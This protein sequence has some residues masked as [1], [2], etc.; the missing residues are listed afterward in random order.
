MEV[1]SETAAIASLIEM[2]SGPLVAVQHLRDARD[3][4]VA[5][6]ELQNEIKGFRATIL[7]CNNMQAGDQAF[8]S[9]TLGKATNL[10]D[11]ILCEIEA[12]LEKYDDTRWRP[13]KSTNISKWTSKDKEKTR[14]LKQRLADYTSNLGMLVTLDLQSKIARFDSELVQDDYMNRANEKEIL[15][16]VMGETGSGKSQ[17]IQRVT[18]AHITLGDSLRSGLSMAFYRLPDQIKTDS[19]LRSQPP[20]RALFGDHR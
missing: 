11:E 5:I 16:A 7:A 15:I 12:F 20:C 1:L 14:E 18:D 3:A 19:K 10:M 4:P 13:I 6:A 17:F 8:L 9:S 2:L